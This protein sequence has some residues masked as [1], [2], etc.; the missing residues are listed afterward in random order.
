MTYSILLVLLGAIV[1]PKGGPGQKLT[2]KS[3]AFTEGKT[4]PVKYTCDGKNISPEVQW[5][6]VPDGTKS[7][8]LILDDPDAPSKTWVH[9]V[10]F[11][12]PASQHE[13]KEDLPAK[14]ELDSGATFGINDFGDVAYGGPCPPNGPAHQYVLKLYALD[15]KLDLKP[16]ATKPQVLQAMK[17]HIIEQTELKEKY[18]RQ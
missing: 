11:N 3:S 2:L 5:S 15:T 8:A 18:K 1:Q 14:K 10:L 17:G 4:I 9:W 6:N 7:F 13:L 16:G 12:I